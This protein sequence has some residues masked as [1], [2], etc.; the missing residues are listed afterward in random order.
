LAVTLQTV[1]TKTDTTDTETGY[2][3]A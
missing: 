2:S 1:T 3:L